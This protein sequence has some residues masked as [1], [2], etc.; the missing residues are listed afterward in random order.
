MNQVVLMGRLTK[1]PTI[2]GEGDKKVARFTLAVDRRF[3]KE[4][5]R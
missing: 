1:E 2:N 3:K 4:G 5:A